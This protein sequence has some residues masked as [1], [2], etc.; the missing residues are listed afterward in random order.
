[1]F[2]FVYLVILCHNI[3]CTAYVYTIYSLDA[4]CNFYV[5]SLKL[6][7]NYLNL[8]SFD[9]LQPL[10][11]FELGKLFYNDTILWEVE[12]IWSSSNLI[13]MLFNLANVLR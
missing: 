13:D 1:V 3:H 8:N 6:N 12:P 2:S 4:K 7:G 9:T 5:P 10:S 11:L